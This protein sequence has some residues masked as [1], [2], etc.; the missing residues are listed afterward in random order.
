MVAQWV[1]RYG[2]LWLNRASTKDRL[3][4]EHYDRQSDVITLVW[5]RASDGYYRVEYL[6][7]GKATT[8][9]PETLPLWGDVAGSG[10][11][12]SIEDA[13]RHLAAIAGQRS[14]ERAGA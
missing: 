4:R 14:R 12:G 7:K 10:I 3:V 1:K 5:Q 9:P 11:Y 6:V 2:G 8:D 13:E